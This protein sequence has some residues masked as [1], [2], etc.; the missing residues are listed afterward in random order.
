MHSLRKLMWLGRT[1][2]LMLASHP[3][4]AVGTLFKEIKNDR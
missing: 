3:R 1:A 2:L 4:S